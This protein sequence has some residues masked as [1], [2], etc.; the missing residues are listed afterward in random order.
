MCNKLYKGKFFRVLFLMLILFAGCEQ[1]E[2]IEDKSITIIDAET[3]IGSLSE[4]FSF[5]TIA[6]EGYGLVGGLKGTGSAQCP[7]DIRAYL[8]KYIL[9]QLPNVKNIRNFIDSKNTAVVLIRGFMPTSLLKNEKFDLLVTALPQTQTSSLEA[10]QLWGA[11]LFEAGRFG[12]SIKPIAKAEGAVFVD[13]VGDIKTDERS[14]YILG[15]GSARIEHG[16]SLVLRKS[17]FRVS[18]LIQDKLNERFGPG[19]ANAVYDNLVELKVPAEYI[20][21]KTRFIALAGALYILDDDKLTSERINRHIRELA[22]SEDKYPS[23]IALESIGNLSLNKLEVL[24]NSANDEVRLRAARCILNL[25][26]DAG[27]NILRK[28][29]ID[30]DSAYRVEAIKA[31]A[32]SGEKNASSAIFRSFLMDEDFKIR[33]LAYQQL[34]QMDDISIITEGIGREFYLDRISQGGKKAIFI[35]RSQEPRIVMFSTP[36]Y[37]YENIFLRSADGIITLNSPEG[38]SFVSII[39]KASEK[40]NL[41]GFLQLQSSYRLTD[42]IRTICEGSAQYGDGQLRVSYSQI[43]AL[44]KQMSDKGAIKAEFYV[45]PL[46]DISRIIKE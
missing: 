33:L 12:L 11:E 23:E 10:G 2:R 17:D 1:P 6:V 29:A 18:K 44:L 28:L 35:S 3:T 15:G 26:S 37:C 31:I 22:V 25:G 46:P 21:Q 38:Q 16:V 39:I 41:G 45:D 7:P 32:K 9:K 4:L 20:R 24:L 14:G 19:T 30:K 27:L 8:E 5:D 43:A 13:T 36:I 42:I 34:S 40:G